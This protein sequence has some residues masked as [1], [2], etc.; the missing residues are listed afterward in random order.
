MALHRRFEI[1]WLHPEKTRGRHGIAPIGSLDAWQSL[2]NRR[3]PVLLTPSNNRLV[4]VG[5]IHGYLEQ[6]KQAIAPW[7]DSNA[8]YFFTGDYVSKG[9]ESLKTLEWITHRFLKPNTG[10]ILTG[11]HEIHLEDWLMGINQSKADFL[12]TWPSAAQPG[13]HCSKKFISHF[14]SHLHEALDIRWNNHRF[15]VTHGGVEHPDHTDDK[16]AHYIYGPGTPTTDIDTMWQSNES[17]TIQVHGHRNPKL[18]TARAIKTSW[19]LEGIESAGE[20]RVIALTKK[21]TGIEGTERTVSFDGEV[22]EKNFLLD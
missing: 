1:R 2:V 20:V 15:L 12:N 21:E 9:P 5:D 16:A 6:A 4:F 11:N 10:H 7:K 19:N 18:R 8:A 14:L 13:A 3:N 17:N 22:T